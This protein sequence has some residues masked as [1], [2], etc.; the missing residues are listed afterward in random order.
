MNAI[1]GN[2]D[3]RM[4]A[5]ALIAGTVGEQR[6]DAAFILRERGQ[7]VPHADLFCTQ[8]LL[9]RRQQNHLQVTTMNRILR[10]GITGRRAARIGQNFLTV[11]VHEHV[12]LGLDRHPRQFRCQTER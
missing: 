12:L 4:K 8:R 10:K 3:V 2:H 5:S 9:R 11:A 1:R 7:L 6:I